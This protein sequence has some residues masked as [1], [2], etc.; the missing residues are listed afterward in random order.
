MVRLM[1]EQQMQYLGCHESLD[2]TLFL[3]GPGNSTTLVRM[4]WNR[5]CKM[6]GGGKNKTQADRSHAMRIA[7][8]PNNQFN[9]K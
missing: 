4:D 6:R 5:V 2:H 3:L 1:R 8:N 9:K 7:S